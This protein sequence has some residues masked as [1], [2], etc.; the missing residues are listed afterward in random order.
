MLENYELHFI[1]IIKLEN[2]VKLL[3]FPNIFFPRIHLLYAAHYR[4]CNMVQ[5]NVKLCFRVTISAIP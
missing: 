5:R 1:Y 4:K 3:H 2:S